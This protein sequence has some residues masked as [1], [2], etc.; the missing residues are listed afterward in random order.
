[1]MYI[2]I[3]VGRQWLK[4]IKFYLV[5]TLLPQGNYFLFDKIKTKTAKLIINSRV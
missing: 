2:N 4:Y 5:I 1:M 3:V